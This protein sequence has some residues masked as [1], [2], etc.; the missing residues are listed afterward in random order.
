VS[1]RV[2]HAALPWQPRIPFLIAV[3][4]VL[5]GCH[6]ETM[7]VPVVF[8]DPRIDPCARIPAAERTNKVQILYA[9]SR[10]AT[11]A[12]MDMMSVSAAPLTLERS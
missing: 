6:S 2:K 1:G 12:G 3:V 11:D 10:R 5:A 9:T 4:C 8:R 7:P